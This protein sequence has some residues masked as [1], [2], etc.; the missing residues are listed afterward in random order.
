MAL[1]TEDKEYID[2]VVETE[3]FDYG[4]KH[5]TNFPDIKDKKFH[6]LRKAYLAAREELVNYCGIED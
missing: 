5:Y 2:G 3:G 6:Q 4:F 1:T